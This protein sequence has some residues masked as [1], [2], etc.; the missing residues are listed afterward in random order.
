MLN[1]TNDTIGAEYRGRE[2]IRDTNSILD[3]GDT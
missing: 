1:F 2:K 3:T